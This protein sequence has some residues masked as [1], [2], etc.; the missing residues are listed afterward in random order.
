M[1]QQNVTVDVILDVFQ[2]ARYRN[3][4]AIFHFGGHA[5]GYRL[6]LEAADGKPAA[7]DAGGLA[8]FLASNAGCSWSSSTAAPPRG[9][10]SDLLDAGVLAVIATG[11]R[12]TTPWPPTSPPASTKAWP[13]ARPSGRRF[14]QAKGGNADARAVPSF[15]ICGA[16]EE[17]SW[18][19]TAYHGIFTARAGAEAVPAGACPQAANDPLFGLPPLPTLDLPDKPY[20]HLDWFRREDAEIFFGRG[21]DPDLY[22]PPRRPR[23]AAHHALLRP[24]GRGQVF[25][26]GGRAA[27]PAGGQP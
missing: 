17:P 15:A 10:C 16:A 6:L 8:T 14:E 20:R 2:D 11:G 24:V 25:G 21:G 23:T 9:R 19:P 4:I 26:P 22:R 7:A 1:V 12:S 13:A 5:D 18:R 27:A 3:R